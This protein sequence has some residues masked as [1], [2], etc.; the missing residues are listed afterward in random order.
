MNRRWLAAFVAIGV[1]LTASS[2]TL[3]TYGKYSADSK[4]FLRAYNKNNSQS[5]ANKTQAMK[6]YLELYINSRLKIQE[7]YE[8]DY[9]TLPNIKGEVET[10]RSQII[11]NYMSDQPADCRSFP[12]KP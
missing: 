3:F 8:R 9:D 5:P 1:S 11:E 2:Q 12:A 10:L 4:E 7:A 6:D